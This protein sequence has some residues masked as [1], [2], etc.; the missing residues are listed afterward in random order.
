MWVSCSK[1]FLF[2]IS[3]VATPACVQPGMPRVLLLPAR[4]LIHV[5][6]SSS[7]GWHFF[8]KIIFT[9]GQI[10]KIKCSVL[11]KAKKDTIFL[12]KYFPFPFLCRSSS[13][14]SHSQIAIHNPCQKLPFTIHNLQPRLHTEHDSHNHH[15]AA[16]LS[17]LTF[18][19]QI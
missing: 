5:D 10:L 3:R 1:S 9:A 17:S 16:R 2:V 4:S 18:R 13:S 11:L 14:H 19:E 6:L 12:A 7:F 8:W 15:A